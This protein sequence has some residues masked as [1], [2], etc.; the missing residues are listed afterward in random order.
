MGAALS[1]SGQLRSLSDKLENELDDLSL[2]LRETVE[3]HID[4]LRHIGGL[5]SQ[6]E[7]ELD[8]HEEENDNLRRWL[9]AA[10]AHIGMLED[11]SAAERHRSAQE[12]GHLRRRLAAAEARIEADKEQAD[13]KDRELASLREEVARLQRQAPAQPALDARLANTHFETG[14]TATEQNHGPSHVNRQLVDVP[15][16]VL[17]TPAHSSGWSYSM[18][19]PS[20]S[21]V[22]LS[23]YPPSIPPQPATTTDG[24]PPIRWA[25]M[26]FPQPPPPSLPFS[27]LSSH[28]LYGSRTSR[29]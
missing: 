19:L 2:P 18:D 24:F 25:R 15:E 12:I 16:S 20:C 7:E 3:E 23:A 22:R 28:G 6:Q 4:T 17:G 9:A 5:V 21:N 29:W 26:T 8:S 13:A 1:L 27:Q 14:R 10:N 11:K